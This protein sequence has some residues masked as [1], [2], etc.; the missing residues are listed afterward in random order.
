MPLDSFAEYVSGGVTKQAVISGR[1][2]DAKPVSYRDIDGRAI[3]EGD[4]D[5]GLSEA[6]AVQKQTR[7]QQEGLAF[8]GIGISGIG[9]RWPNGV[10]PF[11][12]DA[13]LPAQHRVTDAIRDWEGFTQVRF[14]ARTHEPN[15]VTFRP[16]AGCSSQ[17]GMVGN[18]QFVNLAATCTIGNV[19]HEIGHLLGLFHEQSREDRDDFIQVQQANIIP[20]NLND[21]AQHITDGDD[22]GPY[23]Y[24]SVMHYSATAFSSNGM[25]TITAPRPIGQREYISDGDIA[26]VHHMY[27]WPFRP[28]MTVCGSSLFIIQNNLLH[29]VAVASG[30][31]EVLPGDWDGMT[32]MGSVNNAVYAIQNSR[33][34]RI[35][36]AT[37]IPEVIGNPEWGGHTSMTAYG[38]MLYIIQNGRLHRVSPYNGTW[39][40]LGINNDWSGHTSI[41][42][43]GLSLYAIQNGRLRRIAPAS[44]ASVVVGTANW[45]G[46]TATC[47]HGGRLIVIENESLWDVDPTTGVP[48]R[49]GSANWRGHA[50]LASDGKGVFAIQNGRLHR[51]NLVNGTFTLLNDA[52]WE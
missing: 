22:I 4:I 44:G 42:A 6:L 47:S 23:D 39:E 9:F 32:S 19:R 43:L 16:N 30:A 35:D 2:F 31:L 51:V 46:R 48:Y 36:P 28:S 26:A 45:I 38:G 29:R 18:Q 34:H 8:L 1:T 37:G 25:P 11:T 5:L 49:L 50:A 20:A 21:F 3:F 14:V 24:G 40:P 15:W 41:A 7:A 13:N 27:G 33:L 10:V 12:I 17:V 52:S